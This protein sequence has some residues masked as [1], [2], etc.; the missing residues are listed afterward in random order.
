VIAYKLQQTN[1][2]ELERGNLLLGI[3]VRNME[4]TLYE[5]KATDIDSWQ[6]SICMYCKSHISS[7]IT[8]GVGVG[9]GVLIGVVAEGLVPSPPWG[10][11]FRVI[12]CCVCSLN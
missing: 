11:K 12:G 4:K 5:H 2:I 9:V 8:V 1:S 10:C 3:I 6:F 7:L